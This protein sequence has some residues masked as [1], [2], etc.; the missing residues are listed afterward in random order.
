VTLLISDMPGHY[1]SLVATTTAADQTSATGHLTGK[2]ANGAIMYVNPGSP[3]PTLGDLN[4]L[5]CGNAGGNQPH[6]NLM[7]AQ[8]VTYIISLSGIFPSRN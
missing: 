2:P 4:V 6:E 7:P 3:S 8:C 1:H 5:S